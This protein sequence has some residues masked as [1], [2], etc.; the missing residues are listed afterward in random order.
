VEFNAIAAY[1]PSYLHIAAERNEDIP[2]VVY[3][4]NLPNVSQHFSK[5]ALCQRFM[6]TDRRDPGR[7]SPKR[8]H[9][10]E[11]PLEAILNR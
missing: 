4:V 6:P 3:A 8:R 1:I 10:S 5:A 7:R 11:L 2:I 9:D